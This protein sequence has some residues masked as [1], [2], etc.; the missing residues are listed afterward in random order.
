MAPKFFGAVL[1]E[2]SE[3]IDGEAARLFD[4]CRASKERHQAFILPGSREARRI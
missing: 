1:I 3:R 4:K 2:G